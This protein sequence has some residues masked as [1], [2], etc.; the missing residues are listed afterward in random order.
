[1][2]V[3]YALLSSISGI[4]S[5]LFYIGVLVVVL[6]RRRRLSPRAS[7][8]AVWGAVLLLT[9]VVLSLALPVILG[10]VLSQVDTSVDFVSL[11]L[12]S[13][14][15]TGLI[16]LGAIALLLMALFGNE[17]QPVWAGPLLGGE[18]PQGPTAG[19]NLSA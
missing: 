13:G 12:L 1:M 5:L 19:P 10:G 17:P 11:F 14:V 3:R 8:L 15:A 7:R 4:V 16:H 9:G 2:S 6:V 18:T